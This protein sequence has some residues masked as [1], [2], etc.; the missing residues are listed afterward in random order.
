MKKIPETVTLT[1][2]QQEV[3]K[4]IALG[5]TTNA[6][7]LIMGIS[8]KTVEFHRANIIKLLGF[9]GF[10]V[11]ITHWALAKGLVQNKF[12]GF[13]LLMLWLAGCAPKTTPNVILTPTGNTSSLREKLLAVR[14]PART[15][16]TAISFSV[17][18]LS[19]PCLIF[20]NPNASNLPYVI[21]GSALNGQ[22]ATVVTGTV[23]ALSWQTNDL[24]IQESWQFYRVGF[25]GP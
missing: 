14:T 13:I 5:E 8:P 15:N 25:V 23:A 1:P 4:Q 18:T 9:K 19:K 21:E 24:A 17:K 16:E 2:R 12:L 11:D 22:W 7:A 10:L 6:I 20:F 3:A